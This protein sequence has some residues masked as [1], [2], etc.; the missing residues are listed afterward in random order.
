MIN[1]G[2]WRLQTT[3]PQAFW[4]LTQHIPLLGS[5][6]HSYGTMMS[7]QC[8]PSFSNLKSVSPDLTKELFPLLSIFSPLRKRA[9]QLLMGK[10]LW[11]SWRLNPIPCSP[12]ATRSPT[13]SRLQ[14]LGAACSLISN[15]A[16]CGKDITDEKGF[17]A[18][19][20]PTYSLNSPRAFQ[21]S[22]RNSDV[23]GFKWI[24]TLAVLESRFNSSVLKRSI[25][26][27]GVFPT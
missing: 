2:R 5:K 10:L 23:I 13:V 7:T 20:N 22:P 3:K 19:L 16:K 11:G 24:D 17:T 12:P 8:R 9:S 18:V 4:K 1:P 21:E 26:R 14:N 6:I 25:W 15:R 27:T